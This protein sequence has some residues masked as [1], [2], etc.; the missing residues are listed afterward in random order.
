MFFRQILHEEKSCISYIIGC[1]T[2]GVTAVIDPQTDI[3]QYLQITKQHGLKITHVIET[4]VQADHYS[5]AVPLAQE[6][7]ASVYLHKAAPVHFLHKTLDDNGSLHLGNRHIRIIHTPGHT[8]DSISLL[9][10]DWFVLTGDTLFVGDVG[11]VDL[12]LNDNPKKTIRKAKKLYTSLFEKLLLLPD[13]IEI[14]PGHYSGSVC[15]KSMDGKPISTI[16]YE[17][18]EN[19][20]LKVSSRD[21]FIDLMTIDVPPVPS[22][23][24]QIKKKNM[25]ATIK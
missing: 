8:D 22:S 3:K 21:E 9:V 4:H 15:G 18:R 19:H 12:S 11:R 14:Y 20:S 1:P 25:G 7:N 24:R 13:Y 5:G 2:M 23:Y 17:R 6:S 16:G 10:D